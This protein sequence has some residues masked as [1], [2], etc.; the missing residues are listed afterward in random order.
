MKHIMIKLLLPVI[1]SGVKSI[2][3]YTTKSLQA[4]QRKWPFAH[5]AVTRVIVQPAAREN[6]SGMPP[7]V[8][9]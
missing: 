6:G 8:R 7:R 5:S 2:H 9:R 1:G 3:T 4:G